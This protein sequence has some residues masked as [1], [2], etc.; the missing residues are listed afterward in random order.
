MNKAIRIFVAALL[1]AVLSFATVQA[2]TVTAVPSA[3]SVFVDGEAVAFRAFN[4]GGSNFFMLRDIAYALNGT[5]SQFDVTWDGTRNAIN[6]ITGAPYDGQLSA[7]GGGG[8]VEA[9]PSTAIVY[10]DGIRANLRA[11]NIGGNNFFMLVN[12]GDALGFDVEW[13]AT[14]NAVMIDSGAGALLPEPIF[15]LPGEEEVWIAWRGAVYHYTITCNIPNP[16]QATTMTRN[17]AH[18]RG[19][20][21]RQICWD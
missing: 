21:T 7:P 8:A 2:A 5:P 17:E 14:L 11:Y 4:I 20:R 18:T 10:V 19:Y 13:N 15:V 9:R 16:N 1:M 6:L 3:H 12:L